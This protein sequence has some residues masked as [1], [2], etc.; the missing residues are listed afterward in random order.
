MDGHF[1]SHSIERQQSIGHSVKRWKY[2]EIKVSDQE[3]GTAR[4][5]K[6]V[7]SGKRYNKIIHF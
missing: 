6:T 4:L 7:L 5:R 2:K 3:H 1:N